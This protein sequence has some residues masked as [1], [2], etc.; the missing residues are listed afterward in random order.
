MKKILIIAALLS[1]SSMATA[2]EFNPVLDIGDNAPKWEKLPSITDKEIAFDHFKEHKILV[3]AFTCNSCPY[4]VDYEDRLVAF[5]EKYA[6]SDSGVGFVAINVNKIPEDNLDAMKERAKEKGFNFPYLYDDTQQIAQKYGAGYTPEFFVLNEKRQVV[7]MGA[8]DD[9]P[10]ATKV[11][12][13]W[14]EIAIAATKSGEEIKTP[15][16]IAIGCRIRFE[17]RRRK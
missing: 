12:K 14:V 16:T 15:E 17:R 2:G 4:A 13:Q 6:A 3:V 8:F 1:Y 5:A 10:D 9:S 7:Y 11:K